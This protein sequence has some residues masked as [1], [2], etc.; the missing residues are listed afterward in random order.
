APLPSFAGPAH[1][2]DRRARRARGEA[3]HLR[4]TRGKVDRQDRGRARET[5]A[6]VRVERAELARLRAMEVPEHL[7]DRIAI[8]RHVPRLAKAPPFAVP[9]K[10]DLRSASGDLDLLHLVLA[11]DERMPLPPFVRRSSEG[12]YDS[13]ARAP[14]RAPRHRIP[15]HEHLVRLVRTGRAEPNHPWRRA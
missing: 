3:H 1:G 5:R 7:L 4:G 9:P 14:D 8:S 10:R 2:H 11:G 12:R 13:V 15:A 6:R